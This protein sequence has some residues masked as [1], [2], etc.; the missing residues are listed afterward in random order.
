[1]SAKRDHLTSFL[2][3][4]TFISFSCLI[5]MVK[6][7]S[8]IRMMKVG[9]VFLFQFSEERLSTFLHLVWYYLWVCHIW[10]VLFWGLL[11]LCRVCWEFFLSWCYIRWFLCAYWNDNMVFVIHFCWCAVSDLLVCV[12]WTILSS[13]GKFHLITVGLHIFM[14]YWIWFASSLLKSFSFIFTRDIGL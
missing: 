14:C 4:M 3:W 11:L 13:L 6:T 5:F 12:S 7:F 9:I 1:M 8:T 2:I 10:S